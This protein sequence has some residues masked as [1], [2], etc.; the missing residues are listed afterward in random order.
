MGNKLEAISINTIGEQKQI[1]KMGGSVIATVIVNAAI[2]KIEQMG[3][4]MDLP[5]DMAADM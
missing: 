5:L 2:A 3:N 1:V 4:S